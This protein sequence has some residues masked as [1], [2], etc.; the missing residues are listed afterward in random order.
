MSRRLSTAAPDLTAT[1]QALLHGKQAERK[2]LLSP[3]AAW[4]VTD[5]LKDAPP[6]LNAK[7]GRFAYKTGTSYGYRDAWAVGYDG[8]YVVAVWV[9][10][11]DGAA[12]P[13]LSGR[14]AAAPILFD[15][16][17][18]LGERRA[19][20]PGAPAGALHMT[21]SELP[22][23]LKRFRENSGDVAQGPFIEQR[24]LISSHPT[25][26]RSRTED[27]D[28]LL[29]KATGGVLPL[30]WLVNG[31]PINS[32]PRARQVVWQPEGSGLRQFLGGR[33]QGGRSTASP[34]GSSHRA[35]LRRW[36]A[37]A[38]KAVV[39]GRT[40][41]PAARA[42]MT[43][44]LLPAVLL[45]FAAI[46]AGCSEPSATGLPALEA[47]TRGDVR[48]R[49]LVRRLHGRAVRAG[50]RQGCRRRGDH[51]RR[52]I[53]LLG[54]PFRRRDPGPGT[55]LLNLT[56]AVNGCMLN[57]LQAFGVPDPAQLAQRAERLAEHDRI[58]PIAD[59]K[60]DRIYLFT[61]TRD[62]T[63]VRPDRRRRASLL[64]GS[65]RS[66]RTDPLRIEHP[67]WACLRHRGARSECDH[68]GKPYIVDCDYDQAGALLKQIYGT[69]NPPDE[70][71]TGELTV[72]DQGPFTHDL[73]N[74]GLSDS[75]IVYV[76]QACQANAGCRV[77]IA[78]HGCG[79]NRTVVGRRLR[80]RL[81]LCPLGRHQQHHR[82]VPADGDDAAQPAGLL[83]L[84]GV[85]RGGLP[86]AQAPQIIAV[87]RMLERLSAPRTAS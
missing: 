16:F 34:Y 27:D 21:G 79:Q 12:T 57:A 72:F 51:R 45:A 71:P 39:F 10:R 24:V 31:A 75:G 87:Y 40:G 69:L 32:D 37:R 65:R 55:A 6:P 47:Q 68:T 3:L 56:K 53:R 36:R 58:D 17:A 48:L 67:G 15:A 29:L 86:D 66:L 22:P 5:I 8:K 38:Q 28:P 42:A 11:P 62:G 4:Y 9:G 44:R 18:R 59:V 54:E 7:A 25:A 74:H 46:A 76:P 35:S 77:H 73:A 26:P 61:G 1:A 85:Y 43:R 30:T 14:V 63:V 23:P 64:R 33:C 78:F 41:H 50:A 52:A 20:L 19:S 82:A 13:G 81:R 2:R 70:Q 83:G 80:P 49:H 60:S 84:V